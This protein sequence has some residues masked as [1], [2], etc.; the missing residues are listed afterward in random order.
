MKQINLDYYV[1]KFY[2]IGIKEKFGEILNTLN[3]KEAILLY[4]Y[5]QI[6]EGDWDK[7]WKNSYDQWNDMNA[8]HVCESEYDSYCK[9]LDLKTDLK[10]II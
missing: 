5:Y 4:L 2:R 3:S 6:K 8:I 10:N 9:Y 7:K 1:S